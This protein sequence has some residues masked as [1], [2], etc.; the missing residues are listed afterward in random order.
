MSAS[1]A[2]NALSYLLLLS[3]WNAEWC[4]PPAGDHTVKPQ[5]QA[6]VME[7]ALYLTWALE[8]ALCK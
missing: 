6:K 1:S 7:R 3:G 8:A 4:E 2:E 5:E